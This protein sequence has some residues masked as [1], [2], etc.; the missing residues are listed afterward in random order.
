[1][2]ELFHLT[3]DPITIWG[4]EGWDAI[5]KKIDI[6][7]AEQVGVTRERSVLRIMFK[8]QVS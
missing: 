1:M 2:E 5:R 8:E 3:D 6:S 4:S 7:K